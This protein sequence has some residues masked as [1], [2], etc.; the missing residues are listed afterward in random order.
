MIIREH[1]RLG[2]SCAILSRSFCDVNK[3][4]HMGVISSTF[5][6]GIREIRALEKEC[7]RHQ[8]YFRQNMHDVEEAVCSICMQN[9]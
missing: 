3:I 9:K 1:Y 8:R 6:N 4:S 2:A 5:V 7:E